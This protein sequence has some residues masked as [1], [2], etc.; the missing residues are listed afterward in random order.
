MGY[1]LLVSTEWIEDVEQMQNM[2]EGSE[3]G[4]RAEHDRV[5]LHHPAHSRDGSVQGFAY[6]VAST[7]S[8][9]VAFASASSR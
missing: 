2:L 4:S 3:A 6:S 8:V 5:S 1:A 9:F 7:R